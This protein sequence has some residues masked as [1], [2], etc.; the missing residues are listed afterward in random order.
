M[1]LISALTIALNELSDEGSASLK[2]RLGQGADTYWL[3]FFQDLVSK[4]FPEYCP[5]ELVEWRETQDESIQKEGQE[6]R[7]EIKEML[8][9]VVF[10]C[11]KDV[12]G[13][14]WEN[15][16]LL[17]KNDCE[18]RIIKQ[19]GD[20]DVD[21]LDNYDWRDW[22][23]VADYKSIIEK[24]YNSPQFAD[25]FSINTSVGDSFKTKK[26]RLG[27]ISLINGPKGKKQDAMTQA[28]IDKLWLIRDHLANY[29]EE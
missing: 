13:D 21:S 29:V 28:E 25:A 23:E 16:I 8:R 4:K 17:L 22:L 24:N 14:R 19:I 11:L 18:G 1:S 2:G 3:R 5:D 10:N 26:E 12:Y 27:W 15:S 6:L 7:N 9:K 20:N